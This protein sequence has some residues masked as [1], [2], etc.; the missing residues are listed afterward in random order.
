[1]PGGIEHLWRSTTFERVYAQSDPANEKSVRVMERLGMA[2][3]SAG[4][5]M[6]TYVLRRQE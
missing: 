3:Q 5:S 4:G 2:P 6:I 1:V